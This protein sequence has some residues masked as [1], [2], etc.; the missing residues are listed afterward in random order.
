MPKKIVQNQK[1]FFLT[2]QTL[3]LQHRIQALQ[4]LK[5]TI[6]KYQDQI[7]EAL[8]LDLG[9][10][11]TEGY[12]SE[13]AQVLEEL[14]HI[15][16]ILPSYT[17]PQKVRSPLTHFLGK[18]QILYDPYGVVLIIA[19][20]N[21]P[22]SL[23]FSPLIGA[24]AG[25][26]CVI[27]K[28]SEYAPHTQKIMQKI[29][30]ECFESKFV[31]LIGGESQI[32]KELCQANPDYVFFTGSVRVGKIIASLCANHL[33]PYTLELGGKSPCIVDESAN[34]ALSSKRI[35]WGKF[36]NAGQ[37]CVAPDYL[38]IHH[39]QK[40]KLLT[41]LKQEISNLY[42]SLSSFGRIITPQH[43]QRAIKLLDFRL[44]TIIGGKYDTQSC[45]L[46][47]T[48]VD[49]GLLT[50]NPA[51][52]L[53][54]M[55]EEIFAPILPIFTYENLQDCLFFIQNSQK[56]LALYLFSRNKANQSKVFQSLSFGG[57]CLNDCIM[58]LAN[59]NLPFGGIGHSGIGHYHGK[60]SI[61]TFTHKKS[62]Y[63]SPPIEFPVRYPP[64]DKPLFGISKLKLL[65]FLFK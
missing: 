12:M 37:T 52:N 33:I 61:E 23:S 44:G 26:N 60:Y 31:T 50:N 8:N 48:L 25:G 45:K 49:F 28:P 32:T 65:Q 57:G 2:H 38:L 1:D 19:P 22:F 40:D 64:Y 18:S 56:P 53:P 58:H 51:L 42:P 34:L 30:N 54:L 5:S 17:K 16:K 59:P 62:L 29:L 24:I 14:K 39:S 36:L 10:H 63:F 15:L 35:V 6:L 7:L 47:P 3:P 55:Q 20:W 9:K 13:I 46:E 11:H 4:K 43:F 21:Y 41:L 27:L